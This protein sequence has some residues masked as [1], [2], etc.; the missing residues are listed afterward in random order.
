MQKAKRS[1]KMI[2]YATL[3]LFIL[4]SLY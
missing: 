1:A 4:D 2:V 3:N